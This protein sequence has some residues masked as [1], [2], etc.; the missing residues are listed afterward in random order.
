MDTDGE[1][2]ARHWER[3][4]AGHQRASFPLLISTMSQKVT[5]AWSPTTWDG[6]TEV[7][8]LPDLGSISVQLGRV[9]LGILGDSPPYFGLSILLAL[10]LSRDG[11]Q[12]TAQVHRLPLPHSQL[13]TGS[14]AAH[15]AAVHLAPACT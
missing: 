13:Q 4:P 2:W 11:R 9:Q 5:W 1:A 7:P 10:S 15:H 6:Q 14:A 3:V 8:E 12:G